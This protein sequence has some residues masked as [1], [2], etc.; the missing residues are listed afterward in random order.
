MVEYFGLTWNE[1]SFYKLFKRNSIIFILGFIAV[2]GGFYLIRND[3]K[4]WILSLVFFISTVII[5]VIRFI[6]LIYE[7]L[8]DADGLGI[9]FIVAVILVFFLIAFYL[10][11]RQFLLKYSSKRNDWIF[12]MASTVFFVVIQLILIF[13]S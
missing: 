7:G 13:E 10:T 9:F 11:K 8:K 4:G 5:I 3:L 1:I 12:M 2:F 6:Q